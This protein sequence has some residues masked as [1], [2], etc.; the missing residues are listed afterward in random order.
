MKR[1]LVIDDD[2][3]SLE[4]TRDMLME[5]GFE[6]ETAD[7]ALGANAHIYGPTPP[8]VILMDVMM[9]FLDGDKKI[10]LLRKREASKSIPV[11]LISA[12]PEDELEKIARNSGA[13]G[14]LTKPMDKSDLVAMIRR[15]S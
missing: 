5:A 3:V 10:E 13:D 12:K 4:M 15:N 2:R 14:F 9:P 6:V 7:S 1:V 8:D 11:I